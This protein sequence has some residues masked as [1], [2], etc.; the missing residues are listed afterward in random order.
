M[1][2]FIKYSFTHNYNPASAFCNQRIATPELFDCLF[3]YPS[4]VPLAKFY[5]E[6]SFNK[7]GNNGYISLFIDTT[8]SDF[9][10]RSL[11]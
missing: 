5:V 6:L 11:H 10:T 4:G 2:S 7:N 9:S 3:I 1:R 8:A